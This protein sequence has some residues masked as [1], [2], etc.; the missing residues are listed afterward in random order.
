MF[1]FTIHLFSVLNLLIVY[2]LDVLQMFL[3]E[4][5]ASIVLKFPFIVISEY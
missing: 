2:P 3:N 4:V 1:I 5:K